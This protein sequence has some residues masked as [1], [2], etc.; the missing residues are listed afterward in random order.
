MNRAL[1]RVVRAGFLAST[2]LASPAFADMV[3]GLSPPENQGRTIRSVP[4]GINVTVIGSGALHLRQLSI[5]GARDVVV[6]SG[7]RKPT[8]KELPGTI[9]AWDITGSMTVF[10]ADINN[11]AARD[12]SVPSVDDRAR[13]T[14]QS[15]YGAILPG[16]TGATGGIT[17]VAYTLT[18]DAEKLQADI[19]TLQNNGTPASTIK[20]I[21]SLDGITIPDE[22]LS[23]GKSVKEAIVSW[24]PEFGQPAEVS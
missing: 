19:A 9:H 4:Q 12:G 24:T 13:T 6:R 5:R 8:A 21:F 16:V 3:T 7:I 14:R 18:I 22:V 1:I 20:Y 11:S 2:I 23:G 10:D 17:S 15:T